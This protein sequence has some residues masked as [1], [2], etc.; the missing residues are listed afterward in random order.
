MGQ[1]NLRTLQAMLQHMLEEQKALRAF[2]EVQFAII[3]SRDHVAV[4]KTN[5]LDL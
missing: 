3:R 1:P 2:V 4:S 5:R